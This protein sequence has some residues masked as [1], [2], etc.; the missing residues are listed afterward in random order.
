MISYCWAQKVLVTAL[1]VFFREKHGFDVWIDDLG[2]T[3][4]GKMEGKSNK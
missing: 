1:A 4:L 2:S 3:I